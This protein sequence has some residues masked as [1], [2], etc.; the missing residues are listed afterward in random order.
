VVLNV[1]GWAAGCGDGDEE[2]EEEA[3]AAVA[4]NMPARRPFCEGVGWGRKKPR[5]PVCVNIV[6]VV[7]RV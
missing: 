6:M 2:E 5:R 1:R 4:R 3:A 7:Y